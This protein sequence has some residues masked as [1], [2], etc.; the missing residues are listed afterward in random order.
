M[1]TGDEL[2][3]R[4]KIEKDIVEIGREIKSKLKNKYPNTK[5]SV[6][7]DKY[8]GGQSINVSL[9][10]THTNPFRDWEDIPQP[11]KDWLGEDVERTHKQHHEN[12]Y[13]QLNEYHTKKDFDPEEP[14]NGA[15]ITEETHEMFQFVMDVLDKYN[16]DNSKLQE[17]YHDVNFY[18]HLSI[19]KNYRTPVEVT[20]G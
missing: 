19:G 20:E 13:H 2:T 5:W 10:E 15:L 16:Y 17:D 18:V 6:T 1:S 4:E 11:V 14:N 9:V 7:T 8:T 3:R 12:G